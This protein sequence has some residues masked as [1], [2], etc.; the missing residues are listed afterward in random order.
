MKYIHLPT[1]II[2]GVSIFCASVASFDMTNA[3]QGYWSGLFVILILTYF[4]V[5][6]CFEKDQLT[7]FPKDRI[8]NTVCLLGVLE[9]LYAVFQLVGLVPD[10]YKYSYFSGSLNNPAVFGMLLSF[11]IPISVYYATQTKGRI[12]VLW[13]LLSLLYGVFIV[14]SDSRTAILA[15]I[16][17]IIVILVIKLV[18]IQKLFSCKRSR[19]IGLISIVAICVALYYYKRDSADGRILIWTVCVEMI[20]D[21]PWLGW[22]FDGYIAHYMDYQADYLITHPDSPFIQLAGETQNPFNEFLHVAIIYGIPCAL[23]FVGVLIWL[24]WY[25]YKRVNE[26]KSILLSLVCVLI[27]WCFFCYPFNISFVWL[28][29]LYIILCLVP[30]KIHLYRSRICAGAVLVLSMCTLY[31]L[32][33]SAVH[34]FRRLYVQ[35]SSIHWD[36]DEIKEKYESMYSDYN[37]D[38]FFLYNYGALLHLYGDYQRS[39]EVFQQGTKYLSDYNMMLLMGDDY[40][41]LE[42][43]DEAI[44]CYK[45]AGE[46]IPSRYLPL[47]YRM[48]LYQENEDWDESHRIAHIILKKE[49]KIKKSKITQQVIKEATECLKE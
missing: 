17:G 9:I 43:Y 14:L 36:Y 1:F 10:N 18:S 11:C 8:M 45:R 25:I 47:Y 40:Q 49:N 42:R 32:G 13:E 20:K 4:I 3:I 46:M 30:S 15:S 27:V 6:I 16:C 34:D 44:A 28:M 48:K 2:G 23:M 39:L 38:A 19:Y 37:E 22:G 26:Y 33:A 24:I 12:K 7:V 35:E 31:M 5:C 29:I 41:K 21:K